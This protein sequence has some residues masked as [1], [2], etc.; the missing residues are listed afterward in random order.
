MFQPVCIFSHESEGHSV[1]PNSLW[2]HGLCTSWNSLG[3]NTT[4]GSLSLLQGIFPTQG[5]NTGLPH[6]RG[7]LYQQKHK[8]SPR[9]LE[10]VGYPFSCGSSLPSNQ[11]GVSC[12]T[13]GFFTSWAIREAHLE[14]QGSPS[15]YIATRKG[16]RKKNTGKKNYL[17]DERS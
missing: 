3:Q 16:K 9:I 17:C 12:I 11:S 13:S 5:S 1:A 6:C 15:S 10:W 14:H 7:I 2:P 8:R 4:V